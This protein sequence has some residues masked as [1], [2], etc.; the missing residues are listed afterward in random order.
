MTLAS[1]NFKCLSDVSSQFGA[2]FDQNFR[3]RHP[4]FQTH[5]QVSL[6]HWQSRRA[7]SKSAWPVTSPTVTRQLTE[8]RVGV[9]SQ[10]S[11]PA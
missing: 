8:Y 4:K 2:L 5:W 9:T 6:S 7:C 3:L 1:L 10:G 11:M